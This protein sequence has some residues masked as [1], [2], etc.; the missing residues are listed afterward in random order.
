MPT[1]PIENYKVGVVG[2]FNNAQVDTTSPLAQGLKIIGEAQLK[3]EERDAVDYVSTQFS[4]FQL[5]QLKQF[6]DLSV[7]SANVDKF[8]DDYLSGYDTG[9][10]P[11]IENA[12]NQQAKELMQEQLTKFRTS[13]G[14]KAIQFQASEK[15][16]IRKDN[17]QNTIQN[18]ANTIAD[19]PELAPELYKTAE[20]AAAAARAMG[21]FKEDAEIDDILSKLKP[22]EAQAWLNKDPVRFKQDLASGVYDKA[23]KEGRI[24]WEDKADKAI[25]QNADELSLQLGLDTK[26]A[27]VQ[28]ALSGV[29]TLEDAK[30][31]GQTEELVSS[32]IQATGFTD[33]KMAV[34]QQLSDMVLLVDGEN[35][36]QEAELA[37]R[38][39]L[40]R[41]NKLISNTDAKNFLKDITFS[42]PE[43]KSEIESGGYKGWNQTT[44]MVNSYIND[45]TQDPIVRM[46]TKKL[47]MGSILKEIETKG[48]SPKDLDAQGKAKFLESVRKTIDFVVK[49]QNPEY[50]IL[51]KTVNN[52]AKDGRKLTPVP[53]DNEN[54][55][56]P[57]A[58]IQMPAVT[59]LAISKGLEPRNGEIK[60]GTVQGGYIFLGGNPADKNNW[61]KQ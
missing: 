47:I 12:P 9:A 6:Q 41:N 17:F 54:K 16:A 53:I 51:G 37:N 20:G 57:D 24:F 15:M 43:N 19:N 59:P 8:T 22:I 4:Q 26:N 7:N 29:F 23:L 52:L 36:Q 14:M 32:A 1:I 40:A 31:L 39:R 3:M 50:A 42:T 45:Y 38:I 5:D 44:Q 58:N 56:I 13:M 30:S 10:S 27:A 28:N 33:P 11:L 46:Q 48:G 18:I 35:P 61:R 55:A 2:N 25:K 34:Y 60:E 49:E 21:T